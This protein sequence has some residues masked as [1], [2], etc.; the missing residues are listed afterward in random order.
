M[1][2]GQIEE[3]RARNRETIRQALTIKDIA[4]KLNCAER[5]AWKL[6]SHGKIRAFRLGNE[7]R[8]LPDDLDAYIESQMESA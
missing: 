4:Y 1:T 3:I 7:F 5:T 2:P 6:V 8:V